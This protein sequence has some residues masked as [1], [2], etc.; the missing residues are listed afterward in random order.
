MNLTFTD[1]ILIEGIAAIIESL[2]M[3]AS[4]Q[5]HHSSASWG[6]EYFDEVGGI[7]R[8]RVTDMVI[9]EVKKE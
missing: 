5:V 1:K 8:N 2:G 6:K 3:I 9:S 4:N 7:F